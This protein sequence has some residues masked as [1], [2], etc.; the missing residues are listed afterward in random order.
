MLVVLFYLLAMFYITRVQHMIRREEKLKT[1]DG[2]GEGTK[3]K[4]EK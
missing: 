2:S 4:N 3:R 1:R